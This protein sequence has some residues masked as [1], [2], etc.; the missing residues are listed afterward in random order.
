MPDSFEA[1]LESPQILFRRRELNPRPA[2]LRIWCSQKVNDRRN[3]DPKSTINES[4]QSVVML[5]LIVFHRNTTIDDD[6]QSEWMCP[7][8]VGD[9][10]VTVVAVV[11]VGCYRMYQ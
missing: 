11:T 6:N 1:K 3:P 10:N 9:T 7:K 5:V 2:S 4:P 8:I